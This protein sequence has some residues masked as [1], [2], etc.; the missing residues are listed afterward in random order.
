[1]SDQA[2]LERF[3]KGAGFVAALDQSGGST[4]KA[5]RLYGIEESEYSTEEEMFDLIHAERARIMTN[6]AFTNERVLG[7]ILFEGTLDR[8]VEGESVTEYLW[9][10]K[11]IVPFLKI[12]KG[13]AEEEN[14]VQLMKDIPGLDETLARAKKLGVFGTKERSVIKS[15]NPEGIRQVVD[16]QFEIGKQVLAAGLMPIL[17]P[18]VDINAP[19]KQEAEQLLRAAILEN[20]ENLD[21]QQVA[22]KVTIPSTDNFYDPVINHPNMLRVVALSGGYDRDDACERLTGN[23]GLIASFSRALLDGLH[24]D[25]TEEQ[26]TETLDTSIEKI[27]RAS[28]GS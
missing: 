9:D 24:V 8:P 4:P 18:E 27:Y 20:L 23:P 28:I 1:M 26:F 19:D 5:L 2:Q 10:R 3:G 14:G 17:E 16:Q 22:L 25:Q 21:N 13:L 11:G 15:A 6:P 7:A 12:D